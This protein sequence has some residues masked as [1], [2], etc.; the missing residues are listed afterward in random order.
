MEKKFN[1]NNS[2]VDEPNG[3]KSFSNT[4]ICGYATH[5]SHIESLQSNAAEPNASTEFPNQ[6]VC[7]QHFSGSLHRE[8]VRESGCTQKIDR[9]NKNNIKSIQWTDLTISKI[10]I[11]VKSSAAQFQIDSTLGDSF[12]SRLK[13]IWNVKCCQPNYCIDWC[14]LLVVHTST[15]TQCY[16]TLCRIFDPKTHVIS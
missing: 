6:F 10:T 15:S 9:S 5:I 8:R 13:Y 12:H 14:V 4:Q 3:S 16:Q 7:N 2:T 1:P 11:F